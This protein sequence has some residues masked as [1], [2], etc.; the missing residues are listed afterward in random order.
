[1]VAKKAATV[2]ETSRIAKQESPA[3]ARKNTL[4]LIQFLLYSTDLQGHPKPMI[5]MSFER[6][7]ATSY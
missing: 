1:M 4:Q 6:Q 5:F 2:A 7:Y 3:V